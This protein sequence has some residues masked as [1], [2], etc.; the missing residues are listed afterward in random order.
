MIC[1][2]APL[3]RPFSNR[4]SAFRGSGAGVRAADATSLR[5]ARTYVVIQ[6]HDRICAQSTLAARV[7][8]WRERM[9]AIKPLCDQR[10]QRTERDNGRDGPPAGLVAPDEGRLVTLEEYWAKWYESPLPGHRRQLR[11]EQRQTGRPSPC[12]TRRNST[13]TTGFSICCAV[14]SQ[15]TALQS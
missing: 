4:L 2:V 11:M 13:S 6:C 10:R 7:R 1:A 14:L 15:H 8:A 12:P 3:T 9:S 5:F